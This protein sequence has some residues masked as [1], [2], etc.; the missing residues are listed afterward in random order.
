MSSQAAHRLISSIAVLAWSF[1]PPLL[2]DVEYQYHGN[3]FSMFSCEGG[4]LFA[5]A[6]RTNLSLL[7]QKLQSF[8]IGAPVDDYLITDQNQQAR[9][10]FDELRQYLADQNT[11]SPWAGPEAPAVSPTAHFLLA[12]ERLH[13][14]ALPADSAP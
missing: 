13:P 11:H 9:L 6:D 4:V 5:T 3:P 8:S 12:I 2:A 7:N 1:A 14:Y 10:L